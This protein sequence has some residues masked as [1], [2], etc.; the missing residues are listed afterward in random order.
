MNGY[1]VVAKILKAEV[2][3]VFKFMLVL[4]WVVLVMNLKPVM[5]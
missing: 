1:D 2:L 5:V 4:I 3:V